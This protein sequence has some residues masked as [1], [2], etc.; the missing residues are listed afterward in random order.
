VGHPQLNGHGTRLLEL[1]NAA[2]AYVL[3]ENP[4]FVAS[5]ALDEFEAL[6][7]SD[8]GRMVPA[9][10]EAN[11]ALI[12]ATGKR[13]RRAQKPLYRLLQARSAK[14]EDAE[15][16]DF[17]NKLKEAGERGVSLQ[18]MS[19]F[20][21][22]AT[23]DHDQLWGDTRVAIENVKA[24]VGDAFLNSGT[25]LGSVR[26][27]GF[28]P[29]DDDVDIAVLLKANSA[30]DAAREWIETYHKLQAEKLVSKPPK[31]NYGVFKLKST[32][33]IN[34]DVFPAWIENDRMY[35]YPHTWGEL[36]ASDVFPLTACS[37]TGLPVPNNA[38]AMLAVN[39]GENW[40]TPDPT[41]SFPWGR[42]NRRFASF[43]DVLMADT[44]VWD[45]K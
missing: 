40:R 44:S 20:Q 11:I 14:K 23:M 25:L 17:Q 42:A 5:L 32:S 9:Y 27:K 8:E 35:V 41:Y 34:I 28:I 21:S 16:A 3:G 31:R 19:F 26:E 13:Q 43:R 7:V 4:E 38:E 37:T 33:G 22:F 18:G 29:H 1:R 6:D 10:L 39:Y 24:L 15:F 45:L 30:P 36:S 12:I 2:L